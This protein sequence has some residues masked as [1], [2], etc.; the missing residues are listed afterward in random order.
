[1]WAVG[2]VAQ[3]RKSG[4]TGE[5]IQATGPPP[6]IYRL[7]LHEGTPPIVVYRYGDQLRRVP[8]SAR[9]PE[10]RTFPPPAPSS[11]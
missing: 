2:E 3:D 11:S 1:M 8:A 5:I 7:M 4:K 6:V 10:E 9:P